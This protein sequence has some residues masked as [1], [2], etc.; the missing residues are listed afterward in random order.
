MANFDHHDIITNKLD[1]QTFENPNSHYTIAS[2]SCAW[3][4]KKT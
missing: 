3:L 2:G 1:L 4:K